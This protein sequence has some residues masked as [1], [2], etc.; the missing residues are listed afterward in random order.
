MVGALEGEGGL[1]V[2]VLVRRA[3][4]VGRRDDDAAGRAL[5][6]GD[7]RVRVDAVG[8]AVGEKAA[9]GG[10]GAKP[11]PRLLRGEALG[12]RDERWELLRVFPSSNA[13]AEVRA[14]TR[15][16][17]SRSVMSLRAPSRTGGDVAEGGGR[18]PLAPSRP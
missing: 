16:S 14:S 13:G 3:L 4:E 7:E 18:G 5:D 11:P 8:D 1:G 10:S 6:E 9:L 12:A 2:G 17:C 15:E